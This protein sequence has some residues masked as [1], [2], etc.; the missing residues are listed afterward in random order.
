MK[1]RGRSIVGLV[2]VAL[3]I[4]FGC[5]SLF[6]VPG[7]G[8]IFPLILS[9]VL[10]GL[11]SLKFLRDTFPRM[12][13]HLG[14]VDVPGILSGNRNELEEV[15][16]GSRVKQIRASLAFILLLGFIIALS[17]VHFLIATPLFTAGLLILAGRVGWK[18]GAVVGLGMGIFIYLVFIVLLGSVG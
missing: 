6:N 4:T 2:I 16:E 15:E 13:R 12:G 11:G 3:A 9:T 7:R 10:L 18:S 5:S 1:E 8:K 14:F 17:F